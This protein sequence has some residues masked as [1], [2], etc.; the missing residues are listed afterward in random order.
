MAALAEV[1]RAAVLATHHFLA[2]A[3]FAEIED[4]VRSRYLPE[5]ELWVAATDDGRPIAFMGLSGAHID[6]LFVD[7]AHHG[8]GVGRRL[9]SHALDLAGPELTVDVNEQNGSALAFYGRLGFRRIGRSPVD[10]AGRPYPLLHLKLD[11]PVEGAP[12]P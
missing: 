10:D 6:S 12:A 8:R 4:L 5:T 9:V 11:G 7:P 1:W 2:P 3:D